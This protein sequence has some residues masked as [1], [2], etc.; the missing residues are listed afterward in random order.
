MADTRFHFKY[1]YLERHFSLLFTLSR[2]TFCA[3]LGT[4][5]QH[6]VDWL[7]RSWPHFLL[8]GLHVT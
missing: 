1:P 4:L 2:W 7:E 6:R 8:R 3:N 5:A